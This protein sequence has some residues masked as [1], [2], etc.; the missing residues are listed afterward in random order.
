MTD[1]GTRRRGETPRATRGFRDS[2]TRRQGDAGGK[3]RPAAAADRRVARILR[4][5]FGLWVLAKLAALAILLAGVGAASQVAG[6]SQFHIAEVIVSGS[7]LVAAEDIAATID[8]AGVNAFAVRGR[9]LERILRADPAIASATVRARLP[10]SIDVVIQERVPAVLWDAN[11]RTLLADATG[12]T[13]RDG[14]RPG[15][16]IIHAPDGP[17]PDPGGRVDPEVVRMAQSLTPRLEVEGLAGGQL[18]YRPTTGASVVL[19]DSARV[20]LGSPDELEHKLAA[21][22]AIRAY[23]DQTHTQA[24][25]I[26]VRFLERPYFR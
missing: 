25:F 3:R 8:V 7:E 9:R 22:Q 15:L 10:D 12:L 14:V 24:R 20:A 23:L 13:L 16:P 17:A 21:Y 5:F 11:G 18:E 19:P 4:R 26:D 6:S 2:A 1:T